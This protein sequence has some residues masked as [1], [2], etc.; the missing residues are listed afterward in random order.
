MVQ[1]EKKVEFIK[2]L[3]LGLIYPAIL[4]NMI[5]MIFSYTD[6]SDGYYYI[7]FFLLIATTLLY[8]LDFVNCYFVK[9]YNWWRF[10]FNLFIVYNLFY[11]IKFIHLI[12]DSN[13]T[14]E[15]P[16]YMN[17]LVAYFIF[18]GN[19]FQW[20]FW[21]KIIDKRKT[22]RFDRN[23]IYLYMGWSGL[24]ILIIGVS[25]FLNTGLSCVVSVLVVLFGYLI[26]ARVNYKRWLL[27]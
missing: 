23:E 19:T 2:Q 22:G 8:I 1:Q 5:Y 4:G 6:S 9:S 17:I 3:M 25:I 7:K 10:F 15:E 26:I 14:F 21:L 20:I 18:V 12:P 16:R 24:S 11:T 27:T 13:G